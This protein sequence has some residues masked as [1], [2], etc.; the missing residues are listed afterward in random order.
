MS[1]QCLVCEWTMLSLLVNNNTPFTSE[2]CWVYEWTVFNFEWIMHSF[3]V[4]NVGFMSEQFW[5]YKWTLLSWL[6]KNVQFIS[7]KYSVY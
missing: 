7:K 1:E 6:V 4:N 2:Q 5:D 3:L